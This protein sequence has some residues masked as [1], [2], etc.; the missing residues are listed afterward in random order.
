VHAPGPT[1]ATLLCLTPRVPARASSG[2]IFDRKSG[3]KPSPNPSAKLQRA[4][5]A[6]PVPAARTSHDAKGYL[7]CRLS[8]AVML[9]GSVTYVT[10]FATFSGRFRKSIRRP[11]SALHSC[12]HVSDPEAQG[13]RATTAFLRGGVM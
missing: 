12:A 7:N 10:S 2:P 6:C 8:S 13:L 4:R 3:R 11:F 9:A 1:C 5:R